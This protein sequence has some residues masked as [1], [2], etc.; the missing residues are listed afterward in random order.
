MLE[1]STEIERQVLHF[2]HSFQCVPLGGDEVGGGGTRDCGRRSGSI[3][4]MGTWECFCRDQILKETMYGSHESEGD[5]SL[6]ADNTR[7]VGGKGEL[8]EGI[9]CMRGIEN[10]ERV[11]GEQ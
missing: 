3:M 11:R 2:A 5:E 7:I 1:V 9:S 4:E 10:Y 6:S 8:D